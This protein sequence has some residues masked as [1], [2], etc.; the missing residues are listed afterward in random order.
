MV[1]HRGPRPALSRGK[2]LAV[3]PI[4]GSEPLRTDRCSPYGHR[5]PR[6]S[7]FYGISIYMYWNEA[8][9]ARPH[10]HAR[11]GGQ[12]A[13]IDLDG[14]VIAGSLPRRALTLVAEWARLHRVEL[15]A[16]W[17]RARREDELEPVEPLP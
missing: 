17:E 9:H 14:N 7:F 12:A 11:Y 4:A 3:A 10:F 6:I 15:E 8:H 13:S 16:N 5:V 1:G 2:R